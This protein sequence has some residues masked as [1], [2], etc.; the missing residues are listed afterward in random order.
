[1]SSLLTIFEVGSRG[2]SPQAKLTVYAAIVNL[3]NAILFTRNNS[4]FNSMRPTI[5]SAVALIT[6]NILLSSNLTKAVTGPS[7]SDFVVL[8]A[9]KSDIHHPK[10]PRIIEVFWH[11]P[12]L[13]WTKCNTYGASVGNP[14]QAAWAGIFRNRTG[15]SKGYFTLN[16]GNANALYAGL[17]GVILAVEISYD[18]KWKYLW[19]ELDS[20]LTSLAFKSPSIVPWNLLNRWQNYLVK[21]YLIYMQYM[22]IK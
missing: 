21:F 7:I 4:R 9:F 8:K 15:K 13:N 22:L 2:W 10:A 5:N 1:M 16:L 12:I 3:I 18:K 19:I 6:T 17:M 14:R 20:K 11:P